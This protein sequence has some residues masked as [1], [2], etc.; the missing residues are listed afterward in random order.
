VEEDG[1]KATMSTTAVLLD[2]AKGGDEAS[3][4]ALAERCLPRLR[5]MAWGRAARQGPFDPEDAVQETMLRAFSHLDGFVPRTEGAF[6]LYLRR[7]LLNVLVDM[8]RK[9]KRVPSPAPLE[10]DREPPGKL[11]SPVEEAVGRE[12]WEHY[13]AAVD[14]LAEAQQEAVVLFVECGLGWEEIA[15]A[16]ESPS[17]DAARMVV[18]RG[19]KRLAE[20][21][22][23]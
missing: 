1:L 21:M 22:R 13:R 2:R 12:A 6:T 16:L 14:Q 11:A 23:R 17:A 4:N 9:G 3:R 5:R 18:A 7:I 10:A 20:L 8:A 15:Q 19:L